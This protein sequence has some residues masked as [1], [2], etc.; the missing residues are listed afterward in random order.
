MVKFYNF[1]IVFAEVPDQTTLAV[2]ISECPNRCPGCHSPHLMQSV[3]EPLDEEAIA[4]LLDRYGRSV[5]CFC[6]M[7]GDARPAEIAALAGVV[8]RLCPSMLTAWYSGRDELPDGVDP[9]AFDY[10]KLGRYV[11]SLGGLSSPSTN[12][13]LYRIAADGEMEDLTYRF[14]HNR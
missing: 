1:D 2:N 10:I 6:F 7:G 11:E 12:Q 3:G 5:T 8:R 13:R 9:R 4:L 14:G